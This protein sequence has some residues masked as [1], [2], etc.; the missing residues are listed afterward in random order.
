MFLTPLLAGI[1]LSTTGSGGFSWGAF[2]SILLQLILPFVAGQILQPLIGNW[3]RSKKKLLMPVDRGSILMVVYLAFSDAV[4]E[5][6]W[7]TFSA[8]D[9]AAVVIVDMSLLAVVL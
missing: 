4:L 1:M 3:I 9:I 7:H 5:G 2:Q 8:T 6:L